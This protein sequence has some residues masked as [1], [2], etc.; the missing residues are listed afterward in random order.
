M[1]IFAALIRLGTGFFFDPVGF[2]DPH[3]VGDRDFPAVVV[4]MPDLACGEYH[5]VELRAGERRS[6]HLLRQPE[7]LPLHCPAGRVNGGADR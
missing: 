7:Q 5:I 4:P 1:R 3:R 6:R 2:A